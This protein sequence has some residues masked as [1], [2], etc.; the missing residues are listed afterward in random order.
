LLINKLNLYLLE[1]IKEQSEGKRNE[2]VKLVTKVIIDLRNITNHLYSE[3]LQGFNLE[4]TLSDDFILI[5][6]IGTHS[7]KLRVSGESTLEPNTA[8]TLHKIAKEGLNNVLKHA[9]AT[10]II[11]T[12][13]YTKQFSMTIQDNS[14]GISYKKKKTQDIIIIKNYNI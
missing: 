6:N 8:F 12:L 4:N 7:T 10:S 5:Q 9:S 2:T 11:V 14:F 13:E 3:N 1:K